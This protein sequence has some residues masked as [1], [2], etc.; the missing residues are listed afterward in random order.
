MLSSIWTAKLQN[1]N[2]SNSK[3]MGSLKF[4]CHVTATTLG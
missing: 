4:F 2:N 1:N 3:K